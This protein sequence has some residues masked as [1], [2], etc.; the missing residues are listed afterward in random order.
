MR[1][2]Q[3][4]MSLTMGNVVEGFSGVIKQVFESLFV[5][6]TIDIK[7]KKTYII[8]ELDGFLLG[9]NIFN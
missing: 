6:H 8:E 7:W 2:K 3:M 1:K 5:Y 4:Y 9:F